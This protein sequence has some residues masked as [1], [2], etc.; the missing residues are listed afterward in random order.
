MSFT[1]LQQLLKDR[2]NTT[3][4]GFYLQFIDI[5]KTLG[6]FNDFSNKKIPSWC[7]AIN[8]SNTP[9]WK[10]FL[11]FLSQSVWKIGEVYFITAAFM[12]SDGSYGRKEVDEEDREKRVALFYIIH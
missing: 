9:H 6:E 3:Q 4:H 10:L 8:F 11:F 12:K 7:T 5:C 2:K 1:Y